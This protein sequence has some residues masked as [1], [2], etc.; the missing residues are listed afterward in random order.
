M[1]NGIHLIY[2]IMPETHIDNKRIAKNTI[3]LYIRMI[4]LMLINLYT[5]RIVLQNLGVED[6]GI[7]NAVGGFVSLFSIVS[8]SLTT[9]ISRFLTF[10]LGT[11]D[12]IK[13]KKIFSS[14]V[15]VQ[16][17]FVCILLVLFETIGVWFLN[18]KM[19]IPIDRLDAANWVFQMAIIT[20]C[21][22]LFS[23]PYNSILIAHEKM[24]IYA[25]ISILEGLLLLIV[26][27][28]IKKS[29]IDTLV[30]YAVLM[31][32]V[33]FIIRFI[34]GFYCSRNYKECH[35]YFSFDK[36]IIKELLGFAG[37]NFFGSFAGVL[38]TQGINLLMNVY[39]GPIVNAARGVGVQVFTAITKL[40]GGF[41]TAVQPQITKSFSVGDISNAIELTIKSTRLAFFI[42]LLLVVPLLWNTDFL[43]SA[44]LTVVPD[45]AVVLTQ[46][47]L[48][49]C[50]MDSVSQP[51]VYLMLATGKI[52]RYQIV[53]GSMNLINFP[54]A[55][56][57]L[58]IGFSPEWTQSTTV[59][60]SLLCLAARVSMLKNMIGFPVKYFLKVFLTKIVFV[61]LLSN[62]APFFLSYLFV[63]NEIFLFTLSMIITELVMIAMIWFIGIT[64]QERLIVSS[65]IKSSCRH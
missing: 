14:S 24:N 11:G 38:R 22:N 32:L 17:F 26:A 16:F 9:A 31:S 52:K 42:L 8:A 65:K 61:F 62:I 20:F 47:L 29:P 54:V 15:W 59:C 10:T 25:Y 60:F 36:L 63:R 18:S 28:L 4:I 30:F 27:F 5:S 12:E 51:L 46:I 64:Q 44:W 33:A 40:S 41:Y 6:F 53:V 7:F 56:A 13:L 37:W 58:E 55:W 34:Y 2:C 45:H 39:C 57:M 23:V 48:I 19:T 43:L 50:L 21:I 49:Q 35:V 1:L 3:M